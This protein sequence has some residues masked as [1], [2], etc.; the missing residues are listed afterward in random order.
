[1]LAAI[2]F[3]LCTIALLP[4]E[5][6]WGNLKKIHFYDSNNRERMVLDQ[7]ESINVEG[8]KR[9][10]QKLIALQLTRFGDYYFEKKKYSHAEAF[11]RK[12]L[13]FPSP[14]NYWAVYTKLEAIR[15][16][17]GSFFI[18]FHNLFSQ[19]FLGLKNFQ[20]SFLMLNHFFNLWFF[21]SIFAFFLFSLMLFIKYFK[22]AGHD[23]VIGEN[24]RVS[25]QK[26]VILVAI[27][28]WPV[29]IISGWM[30]YPFLWTGFLWLY[31]NDNERKAV[32][33][34][35]IGVAVVTV[36]YSLNLMLEKNLRTESFKR[37]QQVFEGHR[38]D[39]EIY[40]TFDNDLKVAQA[41]AYYENGK[42]EDLD[43]AMDILNSTGETF[44]SPQKLDLT[45][46]I[47][48]RYGEIAQGVKY[49]GE[50]LK[51]DDH[52][53][54]ALNNFTIALLKNNQPEAFKSYTTR[55]PQIEALR[56]TVTDIKDVTLSQGVLWKHLFSP[57]EKKFSA[58]TLFKGIL[59]ELLKFPVVYYLLFF[60]LYAM[61]LKR[62]VPAI[63]ESTYCSKCDKI[64]KEA[65]LHR[66]YK[67]CDECYQLF[68]I[69]DVIFLEAKILKEKELKKKFKKKYIF[70]LIGS[71]LF[72]GINFH[73]RGNNR[74][75]LL[76][77]VVFYFLLGFAVVGIIN[78][79]RLFSTA[80]LLFN[81]VGMGALGFYF[82]VNIFSVIGEENGI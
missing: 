68:S 7:L 12:V 27:L 40:D 19:L 46:N 28:L 60:A 73:T 18:G 75:F 78:F 70:A 14:D 35:L 77:T 51:L 50:S 38:Y 76:L 45:G 8:I 3:M 20:V 24:Q 39:K 11:Y 22:L 16:T 25:P 71:I 26:I 23:L 66:S 33:Y 79:N 57:S 41:L 58:I 69:K 2:L 74:V 6:P 43:T 9:P 32:K 80:P 81:L 63:G 72:P 36:F 54:T 47:Y 67:L 15:R 42:K 59:G 10:D 55:Y 37:A 5:D 56:K 34:M 82:L 52:N 13:S 30:I 64:I 29:L 31:L 17:R 4:K 21:S 48:F 44:K 61:G 65:S 49:Y 53:Q 62:F 1:M